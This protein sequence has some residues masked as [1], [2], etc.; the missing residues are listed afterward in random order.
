MGTLDTLYDVSADAA[1]LI[2]AKCRARRART[3]AKTPLYHERSISRLRVAK[4]STS[5]AAL[6]RHKFYHLHPRVADTARTIENVRHRVH[7][8]RVHSGATT[9]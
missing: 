9:A 1:A 2:V 5:L 7:T 4:L 6:E 3:K 8:L